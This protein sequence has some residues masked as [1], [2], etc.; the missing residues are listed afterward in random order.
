MFMCSAYEI[1]RVVG[2]RLW[3]QDPTTQIAVAFP[4]V[5]FDLALLLGT[6]RVA[7]FSFLPTLVASFGVDRS[8]M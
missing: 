1:S 3:I 5:V 8:D 7:P 2:D 4:K 6:L